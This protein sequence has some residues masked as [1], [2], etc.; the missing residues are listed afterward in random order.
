[1]RPPR[2][3]ACELVEDFWNKGLQCT[4]EYA[5]GKIAAA[6]TQARADVL[7]VAGDN[8]ALEAEATLLGASVSSMQRQ[9]DDL[10]AERARLREALDDVKRFA[11]E[12][13]AREF[14]VHGADIAQRIARHELTSQAE[15]ADLVEKHDADAANAIRAAISAPSGQEGEGK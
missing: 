8:A 4:Q 14:P 13:Y 1:M 2:E 11:A 10:E 9:N 3:I 6:I 15:F 12:A 7:P 5:I